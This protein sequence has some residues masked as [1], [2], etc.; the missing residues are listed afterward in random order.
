MKQDQNLKCVFCDIV[1]EQE[2]ASIIYED[3]KVVA[4]MD[5]RPV[6]AGQCMVIPKQHIDHFTDI[7]DDL[8]AHIMTVGQKIG[9]TMRETL[10]PQPLRIGYVVHGFGVSHAHLVIVPQHTEE[11]I[12]SIECLDVKD[13][14]IIPAY[15]KLSV[16]TRDTLD[17]TASM[18]KNALS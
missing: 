10:N 12:T 1:S 13:G 11:D 9:R 2:P 4:F 6:R 8:S 15:D 17:K 14:A 18:L 3:E 16:P 5:L 7:A